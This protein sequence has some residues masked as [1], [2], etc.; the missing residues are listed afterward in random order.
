MSIE[1]T[2]GY[3]FMAIFPIVNPIGMSAVFLGLTRA[4][5]NEERHLLARHVS[6][7]F[8]VLLAGAM[9]AGSFILEF[10]GITI[11]VVRVAGG[12]LVFKAAWEMLNSQPKL[13]KEE[14]SESSGPPSEIAFFPLTMPITAGAGTLAMALA[15]AGKL[16]RDLDMQMVGEHLGALI[17]L[18]AVSA[19]VFVCYRFADSIFQRLGTVG[20]NVVTKLSAFILLTVGVEIVWDGLEE[21]ISKMH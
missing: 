21:L 5:S 1:H 19:T 9:L 16:N 7:Y 10:F 4:Y 15:I 11:G 2:I 3:V 8:F 20:T 12:M 13:S 17:G 18:A 6:L 14:E